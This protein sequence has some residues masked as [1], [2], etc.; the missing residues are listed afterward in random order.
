M[1]AS[2]L[3]NQSVQELNALL[4]EQQLKLFNLKMVA[5]DANSSEQQA[6]KSHQFRVIRKDIARIKTVINQLAK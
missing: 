3:K 1:K 6:I 5:K 2:E 4:N